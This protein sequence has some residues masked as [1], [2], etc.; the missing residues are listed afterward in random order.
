MDE[1]RTYSFSGVDIEAFPVG[2]EAGAGV[3]IYGEFT[4]GAFSDA[5][6]Y[7]EFVERLASALVE[8]GVYAWGTTRDDIG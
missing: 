6:T 5:D 4:D 8:A 3:K 7:D 1:R 2:G